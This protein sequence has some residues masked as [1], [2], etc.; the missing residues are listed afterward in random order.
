MRGEGLFSGYESFRRPE[1]LPVL[2]A[3]LALIGGQEFQARAD[4]A[5]AHPVGKLV[6]AADNSAVLPRCPD[7]VL[8]LHADAAASVELPLVGAVGH[9]AFQIADAAGRFHARGIRR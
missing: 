4:L 2:D 9:A 7:A 5:T 6:E 3:R 1:R 8:L